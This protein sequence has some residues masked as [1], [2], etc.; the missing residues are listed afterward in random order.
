MDR[1]IFNLNKYSISH[2]LH[3]TGT[4][5]NTHYSSALRPPLCQRRKKEH[6]LDRRV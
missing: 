1:S 5:I 4:Q 6:S 3:C 2:Y